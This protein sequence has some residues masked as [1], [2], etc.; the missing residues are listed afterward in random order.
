M[1][2]LNVTALLFNVVMALL[3]GMAGSAFGLNAVATAGTVFAGGLALSHYA[4]KAMPLMA[5]QVEIWQD[6][7]VSN[8]FKANPF[9][10]YAF[11]GDQYVLAGKVVHIPN[12]GAKPSVTKNRTSL[13]AAIAKRT[14]SDVTY[15]LAEYTSDPTLIPDADTVELSYDKRQ[16][17]ITEHY[18]TLFETVG[19]WMLYDWFTSLA[20]NGT[21]QVTGHIVRTTGGDVLAHT[22][23]ATGN[24]KKLLK[25]D[26]KAAVTYMNKNNIPK[27]GR[28]CILDSEMYAQ[29]MDDDDLKK[30]D[31]ANGG[32]L[33]LKEGVVMK[34]YGVN[35]ME[36]SSVLTFT[37]A[38]TPVI[39]APGAAGATTDNAAA[40]VWQQN[41]VER[42]LGEVKFF[43][44][45]GKPEYYGDVYSALLRAGGRIR[46][47][48]GVVA[49]VQAAGS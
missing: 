2:N 24:R 13:P 10:N 46:R 21:D 25:D 1:K 35:I 39:K 17:V 47:T 44:D 38:A 30:R 19:D 41:A 32:E 23:S 43:E 5:I 49:I 34:L 22:T 20:S 3:I 8:L 42:A 37:N 31:G 15:A 11:N 6:S 29:L 14:D 36:R 40:L 33:N 4:P 9:L 26:I 45:L 18:E 28:Y 16:S 27:D 12:A 7:I 48:A